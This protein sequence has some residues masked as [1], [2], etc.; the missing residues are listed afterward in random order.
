VLR[1]NLSPGVLIMMKFILAAALA[2]A[3]GLP[4]AASAAIVN[5]DASMTG[6]DFSVCNGSHPQPGVYVP[7]L[8]SPAQLTLGAGTY[9]ITNAAGQAGAHPGYDAW[10]FNDGGDQNWVWAFLMVD[11]ASHRVLLDSVP[12]GGQPF[13]GGHAAAAASGASYTASFTLAGKTTL[14]FVTEDYGP[15]D[16]L[17]GVALKIEAAGASAAP[18]PAAWALMIAGFGLAGGMLRRRATASGGGAQPRLA[19]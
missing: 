5:I 4:A 10:N 1:L 19:A 3:A 11:D 9:T 18:E 2:L 14:D 17:G 7:S 8:F 6:C 16:N 12:A 13:V 15:Y